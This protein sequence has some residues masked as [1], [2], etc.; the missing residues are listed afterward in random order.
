[1][2]TYSGSLP[3]LCC[4]DRKVLVCSVMSNFATHDCSQLGSSVLWTLQSRILERLP[5]P[6]PGDLSNPRIK[7]RSHTLQ[8]D[9][10]PFE[11]PGSGEEDIHLPEP[12][13][14]G[15]WLCWKCHW[16]AWEVLM[17]AGAQQRSTQS[18][19]G[20]HLLGPKHLDFWL[21]CKA[22]SQVGCISPQGSL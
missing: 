17:V 2:V 6:S 9:Y 14:L 5:F 13:H 12:S 8:A 1:M 7:L 18:K 16:H 19:A 21:R 20:I 4:W 10:L 15:S 11:P 22:Q 3:Q